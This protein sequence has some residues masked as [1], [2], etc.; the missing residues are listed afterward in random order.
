M[1]TLDPPGLQEVDRILNKME[2]DQKPGTLGWDLK[3]AILS[4]MDNCQREGQML[5]GRLPEQVFQGEVVVIQEE[6][7][8]EQPPL[9]LMTHR[10]RPTVGAACTLRRHDRSSW[11]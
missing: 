11:S 1:G 4:L 3:S 10:T 5:T 8:G 6:S 7:A 9:S 2:I